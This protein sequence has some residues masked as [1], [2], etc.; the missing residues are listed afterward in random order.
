MIETVIAIVAFVVGAMFG[1]WMA[2][3]ILGMRLETER[4]AWEKMRHE[5]GGQEYF[6]GV[7][8]GLAAVAA[9]SKRQGGNPRVSVAAADCAKP[10]PFTIRRVNRYVVLNLKEE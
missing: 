1:V 7:S 10:L 4:Q 9:E 5:E 3:S 8:A 2:W 6:R